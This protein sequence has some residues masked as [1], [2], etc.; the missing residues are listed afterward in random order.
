[1]AETHPF[2]CCRFTNDGEQGGQANQKS[3]QVFLDQLHGNREVTETEPGLFRRT[4]ISGDGYNVFA[5]TSLVS[6]PEYTVHLT[7]MT[8]NG[9]ERPGVYPIGDR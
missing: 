9:Y 5:L 8:C 4:E 6:K 7:K 2:L 3:A 1:M